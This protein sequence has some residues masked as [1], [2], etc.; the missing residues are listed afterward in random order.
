[1]REV[2]LRGD[3]Q[4]ILHEARKVAFASR[5]SWL[6]ASIVSELARVDYKRFN[7]HFANV[8]GEIAI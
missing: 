3:V 1:L 8:E 6:K 5:I 7:S 4:R 2:L